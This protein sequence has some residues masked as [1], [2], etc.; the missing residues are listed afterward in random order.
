MEP[1][2]FIP[3]LGCT[4]RL[5]G[6]Q[7]AALSGK[8]HLVLANHRLDGAIP[9]IA[10]SIL[11]A[12]PRRFTVVG[13]SMGGFISLEIMRQ[14]GERVSRLVLIDTNARADAPERTQARL[15]Q[16]QMVRDGQIEA[17]TRRL[18]ESYVPATR[19]SEAALFEDVR[20]MALA[21]G[22]NVFIQQAIAVMNRPDARSSLAAIKTPT[23]VVVGESDRLSPP[24]LSREMADAI[25]GAK[26][27][28]LA[29]CGHLPTLERPEHT[30]RLLIDFLR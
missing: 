3:G 6:P 1:I 5:F 30:S 14:A 19:H 24:E 12:A 25:K 20:A 10:A 8:A 26:L 16:I 27:V 21:T 22:P 23:L 17:L 11:T 9:A 2:V 7:I 28:T 4:E 18:F 13:L 15:R 29:D